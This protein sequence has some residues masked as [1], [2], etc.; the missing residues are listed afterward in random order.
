MCPV[1]P[2]GFAAPLE[3]TR[4]AD[5]WLQYFRRYEL[6]ANIANSRLISGGVHRCKVYRVFPVLLNKESQ[7]ILKTL[8]RS[9]PDKAIMQDDR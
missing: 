3:R 7:N 8:R 4:L 5:G 6:W 2:L 1:A 9:R